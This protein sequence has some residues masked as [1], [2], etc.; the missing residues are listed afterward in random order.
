[1]KSLKKK[2]DATFPIEDIRRDFPILSK[3]IQGHQL[4]YLD[5]AA[6]TQKP[7][8]VL[9][10]IQKYYENQNA[11]VH[12]SI[13]T[14][15]QEATEAYENSRKHVAEFIGA[16]S[17]REVVFTRGT[18]ESINL[19]VSSFARPRLNTGDVLLVSRMEHHSNFVPWQELAKQKNARFKILELTPDYRIDEAQ[20]KKELTEQ[21][22]K[23]VA[24]SLMS[25][26]L[27]TI[28]PVRKLAQWAK[29]A[30]AT[31][32][33]DGAQGM[34]HFGLK[35]SDL[36]PIDF[37]CFSSH[38]MCGPTGVGVL[39][40]R[41]KLLEE[42]EPYQYGGEMILNVQD[43]K[44]QWNELPWKFEAGTPNIAGVIGFQSAL[45]YLELVGLN[46][47]QTYEQDLGR[48]ALSALREIGGLKIFGPQEMKER[49]PVLS[50]SL[51]DIHPHD[52]AT[53]LDSKGISIRA[54]HHCAIPLHNHFGLGASSRAS[55]YFYNT[56]EEV[57]QLVKEIKNA[58][59]Y[60]G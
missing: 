35:L 57:D 29:E 11:N 55:F 53:Y 42:M 54:G 17:E 39:W 7:K 40:G 60:F 37:L 49:G 22:P 12:R 18:T 32:I 27:G 6:T 46:A 30:G 13:H 56:F 34:A 47:V 45:K 28:N 31:T 33:I 44:S 38:K 25:N 19:I 48:Y 52:L 20:F 5:N 43:D 24:L 58:K 23:I 4:I 36:G 8:S 59:N 51:K 2:L 3:K 50:F 14:L 15:G 10:A 9:K 1:L 16:A 41:E 21:H 26:V